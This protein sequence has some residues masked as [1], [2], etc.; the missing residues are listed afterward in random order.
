MLIA[1]L[2]LD[3][4]VLNSK[5]RFALA[6]FYLRYRFADTGPLTVDELAFGLG[7]PAGECA[8]ALEVLLN[9]SVL[10][11]SVDPAR[12]TGRPKRTFRIYDELVRRLELA[13]AISRPASGAPH[14]QII[15]HLIKGPHIHAVGPDVV[16]C[17]APA[18]VARRAKATIAV[19][20]QT[21]LI[22]RS[23]RLLLAILFGHA[24]G[25]G[26]V[27]SLSNADICRLTGLELVSIKQRIRR[28]IELG[29]IRQ[30]VPGIAS[31][32]FAEKLKSSYV[33]NL[34]HQQIAPDA[35]KIGFAVH[36][37]LDELAGDWRY[38]GG[39]W[40]DLERWRSPSIRN[41]PTSSELATPISAL[42]LFRRAP[43]HAF[44]RLE[45]FLT[46]CV[47][48][49]LTQ[50]WEQVGVDHS[51]FSKGVSDQVGTFFR[52]PMKDVKDESSLD[53]SEIVDFLCLLVIEFAMECKA[54][55][56][57]H[58]KGSL[59]GM[60]FRLLPSD[61]KQGYACLGVLID[62]AGGWSVT[63]NGEKSEAK[64]FARE[65]ALS[66][67]LRERSGLLAVPHSGVR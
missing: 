21:P 49:L 44:E 23:N 48:D 30:H 17:R 60:S 51:E 55:F 13:R 58:E 35:D 26:V 14:Q 40:F 39:V 59:S 12:K 15:E 42:R 27:S 5:A 19:L 1:I 3:F 28:L 2:S 34:N 56:S 4:L 57:D 31:P 18:K 32:I 64:M 50:H 52:K 20:K 46:G 29:F 62:G 9:E 22:S 6:A 33:L 8:D 7:V 41:R 36:E 11:A 16:V 10:T 65:A 37:S 54:R 67:V 66:A 53:E 45:F 63:Q 38:L 43:K 24:D 61:L 25:F 47:N